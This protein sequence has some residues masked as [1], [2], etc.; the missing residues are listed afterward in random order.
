MHINSIN[1]NQ[2]NFRAQLKVNIGEDLIS[3]LKKYSTSSCANLAQDI[4]D[5]TNLLKQT[6]PLIGK[7]SDIITLNGGISLFK[8]ARLKIDLNGQNQGQI[9]I[10]AEDCEESMAY[11]ISEMTDRILGEKDMISADKLENMRYTHLKENKV[12]RLICQ[13]SPFKHLKREETTTDELLTRVR[14]L[15]TIA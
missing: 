12:M 11:Y 3:H 15:N 7:D 4:I 13:K 5:A 1:N 10:V 8:D 14:A 9:C 6:A 2:P